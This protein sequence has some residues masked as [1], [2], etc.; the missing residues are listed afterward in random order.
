MRSPKSALAEEI[1]Y[2][3]V[4][5]PVQQGSSVGISLVANADELRSALDSG[6]EY[7]DRVLV[8]ERIFGTE[9]TVGVIGNRPNLE[10]LPVIEIVTRHEFFDYQAKYDPQ[11]SDEICPARIPDELAQRVQDL[12]C[13]AHTAL[14]CRDMSRT[15]MIAMADGRVVLLEVNTIPGMTANS[16]LPKAARTAGIE[17][18]DL[19]ARLIDQALERTADQLAFALPPAAAAR[20]GAHLDNAGNRVSGG[21]LTAGVC[22]ARWWQPALLS[23]SA[24]S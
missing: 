16:L 6:L 7:D 13:R 11:L 12:A 19:C 14:G 3:L 5:K 17:F 18:G 22:W 15:D 1:G 2:P 21:W 9:L 4:A 20:A 23:G 24:G 10:P 8:E